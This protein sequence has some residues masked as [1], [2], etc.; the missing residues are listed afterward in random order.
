MEMATMGETYTTTM[1]PG[2]WAAVP[3]NPRQRDTEGRAAKAKHLHTLQ[4]SHLLVWMA[5]WEGGCCKLEGHTRAL[6]WTELK[7]EIAPAEVEVR[8][9]RVSGIE[10]AK[11]LYD[12]FNSRE[13]SEKS[14][15]R[16]FGAMREAGITPTNL[17]VRSGKFS[18]AVR[19]ATT[20]VRNSRSDGG[21]LYGYSVREA[22][23][24]FR[25]EIVA[26][27]LT[28]FTKHRMIGAAVCCYVMGRR[29]HGERVDDFFK[30]YVTDAG[31]KEGRMKDAVQLF[32]DAMN[33]SNS[34]GGYQPLVEA[35]CVGLACIDKWM[36][37]K[38]ARMTR[39]PPCDPY[40]YLG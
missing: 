18:N 6:I 23:S 33:E 10:E 29:K 38:S 19:L 36:K 7:P 30:A 39:V 37:S 25:E 4:K 32:T 15:D 12:H 35:C 3:S 9:I 21:N 20:F 16:C 26:L 5:E 31:K 34:K 28:G 40:K 2:E 8:V 27:D 11:D 14:A 17:F 22:V 24:E 1:T 13:E